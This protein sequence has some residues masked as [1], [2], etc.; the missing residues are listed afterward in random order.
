MAASASI[1]PEILTK[2]EPVIGLEEG[3]LVGARQD[4]SRRE[5]A[6]AATDDGDPASG[7]PFLRSA[8]R[9]MS[10]SVRIGFR[11]G[12]DLRIG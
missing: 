6:D 2:Y 11:I 9:S 7:H 8:L 10:H 12:G 4:V 5:P 3:H 1:S